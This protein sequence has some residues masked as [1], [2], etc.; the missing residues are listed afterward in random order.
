MDL[1]DFDI[2]RVVTWV[3]NHSF[4]RIAVQF[5]DELLSVAPK[6][7]LT[8]CRELPQRKVFVLGDSPYG[9]SSVDEVGAE[10]YGADCIV[11][12]GPSDQQQVGSLPVLFVFGRE[13][14]SQVD[15]PSILSALR[16]SFDKPVS[17]LSLVLVCDVALQHGAGGI[18]AALSKELQSSGDAFVAEPVHEVSRGTGSVARWRDWR[19][20]TIPTG[21]WLSALGPLVMSSMAAPEPF[22]VCGRRV[23]RAGSTCSPGEDER[24]LPPH[25]GFLHLGAA[26]SALERRLLLRYGHAYPVWRLEL[27]SGTPVRL[28]SDRLLLQRYRLV[29]AV[30]SAAVVGLLL[31]ATGAA[32]GQA[33]AD[34]LETLLR[35]AG[36]QVYRFLLGRPTAE[37]LGN[38]P[39]VECY[40]SLASPEHFPF[41]VRDVHV[42]IASPYEVE[43]ALGAR[44]WSGDYITDLEELLSSPLSVGPVGSEVFAVQTLGAGARVRT[45]AASG[46]RGGELVCAERRKDVK[47]ADTLVER[48]STGNRPPAV[49]EPGLHG[50]PSRYVSEETFCRG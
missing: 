31:C 3:K 32:Q 2:D 7:V 19:F 44:E 37:K 21:A 24:L 29:E 12:V 22:R 33:V 10:H 14:L 30:K 39:D 27:P 13:P 50:I 1:G 15:A 48:P 25:C 5:P 42:P 11:K 35:R 46:D 17:S 16:E 43:V 45:F 40:V 9:S 34:R 38:F 36:R 20:G 4:Q 8:L 47:A 6:I 23:R 26:D 41:S 28:S 49:V 18:G